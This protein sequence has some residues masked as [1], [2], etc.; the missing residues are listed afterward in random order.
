MPLR[1]FERVDVRDGE[2]SREEEEVGLSGGEGSRFVAD[3]DFR[4]P[5]LPDSSM[6]G[7]T[8]ERRRDIRRC[9]CSFSS[10]SISTSFISSPTPSSGD[11]AWASRRSLTPKMKK[12]P[13]ARKFV[14]VLGIR[15]GTAWPRTAER[16]VMAMRAEKAA[17]KTTMRGWRMAISAAT[18]KVLSP[19]SEKRIMV[20][21]RRKEWRGCII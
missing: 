12:R 17:E 19:T 15:V 9:W 8:D 18:R 11:I 13:A 21:E 20:N 5:A 10:S 4:A 2:F 16:M 3:R 14:K 6:Y 1:R 7:V